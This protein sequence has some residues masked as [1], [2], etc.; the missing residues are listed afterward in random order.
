MSN[1]S[2]HLT[3]SPW[4]VT[5]SWQLGEF[6]WLGIFYWFG[7]TSR[8]FSVAKCRHLSGGE[9]FV[10]TF[11]KVISGEQMGNCL[12]WVTV[13]PSRKT[14]ATVTIWVTPISSQTAFDQL[15]WQ[16]QGCGVGVPRS[17]GFGPESESLIWRALSVSTEHLC[18]VV[19][20][21]LTFVQFILQT[22]LCLYSSVHLLLEELD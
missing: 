1:V 21:Y 3:N 14:H 8:I 9:D 5:L 17:P 22:K 2:S 6:S 16:K 4:A 11:H 15:S 12:G 13:S 19:A 10:N 20:V 7:R 18:N